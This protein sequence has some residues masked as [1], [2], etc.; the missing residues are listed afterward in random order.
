MRALAAAPF[1][2]LTVAQGVDKRVQPWGPQRA[3]QGAEL[4]L[5]GGS[6][7]R[8]A[9]AWRRSG[10]TAAGPPPAGGAGGEGPA[11]ARGR[12]GGA[13]GASGRTGPAPAR[14][15]APSTDCSCPWLWAQ[16]RRITGGTSQEK[17]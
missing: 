2:Y 14:V 16:T 5:L 6:W 10:R 7:R 17:C 1:I 3:H 13:G 11:A 4:I 12:D 9:G 8:A 15:A